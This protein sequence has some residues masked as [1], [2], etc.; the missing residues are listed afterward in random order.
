MKTFTI[1]SLIKFSKRDKGTSLGINSFLPLFLLIL[2]STNTSG[3]AGNIDQ[4]RN[5]PANDP[6]KNFY[7]TFPNPTW[8]NGNGDM[9]S[10]HA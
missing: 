9:Q 2:F 6:S 1:H 8:V 10:P 5:G 7:K 3:Q 4:I